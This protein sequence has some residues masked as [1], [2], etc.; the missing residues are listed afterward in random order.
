MSEHS[1]IVESLQKIA[2]S[3][4][5]IADEGITLRD[6]ATP[7]VSLETVE[8]SDPETEPGLQ[9]SQV[10]DQMEKLRQTGMYEGWDDY[11]L[12]TRAIEI[13]TDDIPH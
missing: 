8:E 13:L 6:P 3:L 11:D 10:L 9:E 4:Q 7:E 1:G 2:E 5:K 12:R